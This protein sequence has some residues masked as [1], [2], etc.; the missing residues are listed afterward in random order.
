MLSTTSMAARAGACRVLGRCASIAPAVRPIR[1]FAGRQNSFAIAG[2]MSQQRRGYVSTTNPNPPLGK[3]NATNEN[4]SRIGLI[5]ARGYT[6]SALVELLNNHPS[7][8]LQHVSSRELAGQKLEGYTKRDVIYETLSPEDVAQLDSNGKVDC[9]ILALPNGVCGPYVDALDQI[10][11]K[12]VIVDL[13]ADYRWDEK[14]T[15]G[16]PELVKRSKIAQSN[17]IANPGCYATGAQIGLTGALD[18]IE[19]MPVIFGCSGYSGAGSKPNPRNNLEVLKDAIIPYSLTGH[20]HEREISSQ[21]N[22][23][24]AFVP[25]VAGWFRG[26]TLTLN[27]PLRKEMTSRDIRQLYQDRYAGEHL[28]KVVGEAPLVSAISGRHGV[29]IGGF[30]VDSTGKRVVIVVTID[31]LAKGA[32]TQCLQNMNLALGYNEY[33]GIPVM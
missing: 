33:E 5:G 3:K 6:G 25:H 11:S 22:H 32:A 21:L 1:S 29:E 14:W 28:I 12:S 4:P 24:V 13:S 16:L 26:I 8:D 31:N 19:G 30:A 18:L 27:I 9:W 2:M 15:Y 20:V 23:E 17:R 10:N 7:I